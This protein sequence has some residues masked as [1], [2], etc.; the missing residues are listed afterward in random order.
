MRT[1]MLPRQNDA[2][3]TAIAEARAKHLS[4]STII[5]HDLFTCAQVS[6]DQDDKDLFGAS[7]IRQPDSLTCM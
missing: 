1:F 6:D 5:F 3:Q 2:L 7:A 4:M